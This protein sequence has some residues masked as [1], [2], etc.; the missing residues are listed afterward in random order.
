MPRNKALSVAEAGSNKIK[1]LVGHLHLFPRAHPGGYGQ[2]PQKKQ[3]DS[4]HRCFIDPLPFYQ[5]EGAPL[6][7]AE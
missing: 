5:G 1:N 3:A 2:W 6:S 7:R 4:T